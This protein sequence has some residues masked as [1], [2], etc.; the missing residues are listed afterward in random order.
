MPGRTGS[1]GKS[2]GLRSGSP[3]TWGSG[4]SAYSQAPLWAISRP[5]PA[6]SV[7]ATRLRVPIS[8]QT[9]VRPQRVGTKARGKVGQLVDH[10][11]GSR[12]DRPRRAGHRRRTHPGRPDRRPAA[13]S[14]AAL[15]ADRVVPVTRCPAATSMGTSCRPMAP[16]APATK[17]RPIRPRCYPL[18][19]PGSSKMEP[20][21]HPP[22]LDDVSP[23]GCVGP[24]RV[25]PDAAGPGPAGDGARSR[26]VH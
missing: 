15:S 5:A 8:T 2:F 16:A 14:Q 26:G 24:I 23:A 3:S 12:L 11:V 20:T 21:R 9:A 19:E 6:A 22:T 7:A 4:P 1:S 18:R 13:R 25:R 10:D 17:I